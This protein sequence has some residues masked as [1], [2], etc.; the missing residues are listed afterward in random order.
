MPHRPR[1][2]PRRRH[3]GRRSMRCDDGGSGD[4]ATTIRLG[5]FA[6]VTHAAILGVDK[7]FFQDA[8]G[9]D[10]TI[11]VTTFNSGTEAAE[12]LLSGAIDAS[13]IGPNPAISAFATSEGEAVRLVAGTT[14]G[15]ASLVVKP[16]I[17]SAADLAG[18]T[19]AT[20]S[21]G[22]T[23]DVALR[24]WLKEEG[25]TTDTSG[26]GDVSIV[27]QENADTLTGF[28]DGTIDGAWVPELVMPASCSRGGGTVLV[29]EAA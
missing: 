4:E 12:A 15:G 26:G 20:P 3:P 9:E 18:T 11:E 14:S 28:I 8:L 1:A 21:L 5:Y 29:D 2:R 19:L 27:P 22:N 23:Q 7:G 24:S 25:Y 16:E 6:N 17:T 13:F 10:V